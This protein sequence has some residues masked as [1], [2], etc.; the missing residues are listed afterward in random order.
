[1][2]VYAKTSN[3]NDVLTWLSDS[4]D[5]IT[6]SQFAILNTAA[7]S[8]KTPIKNRADSHHDLIEQ[9]MDNIHE[10]DAHIGGQLGKKTGARYQVYHRLKD[11]YDR[12]QGDIF[13][14]AELK[15]AIDEIYS[16]PLQE[17]ARE[18][19]S[20]QLKIGLSNE[21]LVLSILHLRAE[22]KFCRIVLKDDD[23]QKPPSIIC[24]LGLV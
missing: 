16:Y 6:Q 24:S 13:E 23:E 11:Y 9:S 19:L 4:G 3:D 5:I 8:I 14:H 20:R 7:C 10:L 18:T 12:P 17:I 22:N 1:V 21:Q 15:K 2:I